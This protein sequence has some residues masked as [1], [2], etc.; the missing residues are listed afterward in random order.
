MSEPSEKDYL[1]YS[2]NKV[3]RVIR[4][5]WTVLIIFI[6]IYLFQWALPDLKL[7]IAKIR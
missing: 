6:V 2:G 1:V 5:A 4:F 7:W 3:P